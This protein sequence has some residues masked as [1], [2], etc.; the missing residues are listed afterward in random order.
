MLSIFRYLA[1]HW[2]GRQPLAQSFWLNFLCPVVLINFLESQFDHVL[3]YL[4]HYGLTIAISYFIVCRLLIY[5]WQ[6]VG[7]V[8][9]SDRYIREYGDLLWV[10]A[11]YAGLVVSLLVA[12]VTVFSTVQLLAVASITTK[13]VLRNT[14]LGVLIF[15]DGPISPGLTRELSSIMQ[16]TTAV[17]GVMLNSSGGHI[18]ESRGLAKLILQHKLNTYVN[19]SCES[20]CTTVFI[21]GTQR[22]LTQHARLGFHQYQLNHI[23]TH[24]LVDPVAEQAIDRAFFAQQGVS[25]S[26]LQRMFE[27]PHSEL[28]F[29]ELAELLVVGVVHE[30]IAAPS[31]TTTPP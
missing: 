22:Y 21:S 26:F 12:T 6:I 8:R 2:Y 25:N 24:P 16:H 29:P 27:H 11:A 9:S 23:N 14:P 19:I 30:I 7:L 1:A 18:Y 15:I 10:R 4:P 20:A 31:L 28:W 17:R 5:P 13:T 3:T